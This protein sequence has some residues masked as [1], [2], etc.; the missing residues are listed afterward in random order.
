MA[1]RSLAHLR[2]CLQGPAGQKQV[3]AWHRPT[4]SEQQRLL[5]PKTLVPCYSLRF[6]AH[7]RTEAGLVCCGGCPSARLVQACVDLVL[8]GLQHSAP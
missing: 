5:P 2:K 3:S 6:T 7:E 4:S 1:A 8:T